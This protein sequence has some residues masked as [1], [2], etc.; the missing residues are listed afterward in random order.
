MTNTP[1]SEL[2][3]GLA[4]DFILDKENWQ[5]LKIA[6]GGDKTKISKFSLSPMHELGEHGPMVGLKF[7]G[8]W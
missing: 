4:A 6:L 1:V 7:R 5:L 2:T 8:V 3:V